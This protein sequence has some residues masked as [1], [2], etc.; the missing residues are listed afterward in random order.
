MWPEPLLVSQ[1]LFWVLQMLQ[2]RSE[3]SIFRFRISLKNG[4]RY[5]LNH[6]NWRRSNFPLLAFRG[7][8]VFSHLIRKGTNMG[9]LDLESPQ[10]GAPK[11]IWIVH[12]GQ[13]FKCTKNTPPPPPPLQRTQYDHP[14]LPVIMRYIAI[15]SSRWHS[16]YPGQA[17]IPDLEAIDNPE[18]TVRLSPNR[19][20]LVK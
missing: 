1:S 13:D 15:A 2:A 7:Y 11:N 19:L 5:K 14:L 3:I 9:P 4:S 16:H 17:Q 10:T 6:P 8:F 12:F 18:I 20:Y